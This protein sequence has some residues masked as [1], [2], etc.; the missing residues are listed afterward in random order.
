MYVKT[1]CRAPMKRAVTYKIDIAID[2]HGSI[3][4]VYVNVMWGPNAHR[5]SLHNFSV[6]GEIITEETCTQRLQTFHHS[7]P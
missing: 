7:K 5:L 3:V 6:N 4:N 1:E 2:E